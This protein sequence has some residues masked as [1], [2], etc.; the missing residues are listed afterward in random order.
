MPW[1]RSP[2][3]H[4]RG[5]FTGS[6]PQ[7]SSRVIAIGG[8]A[9]GIVLKDARNVGPIIQ[10]TLRPPLITPASLAAGTARK[11]GLFNNLF[12]MRATLASKN[13]K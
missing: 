2:S 12:P 3:G 11:S 10:R 7:F 5:T 8:L 4:R 6:V 9:A 13:D 1:P